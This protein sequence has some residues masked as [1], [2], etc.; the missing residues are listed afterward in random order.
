MSR[1]GDDNI[2]KML[3]VSL[4]AFS[5]RVMSSAEKT[6]QEFIGCH[7]IPSYFLIRRLQGESRRWAMATV[8]RVR[9][10]DGTCAHLEDDV[11]SSGPLQGPLAVRQG[12]VLARVVGSLDDVAT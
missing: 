8:A 7:R 12:L 6:T 11:G 2:L 5:R 1:S 3:M 10:K 4:S 9:F